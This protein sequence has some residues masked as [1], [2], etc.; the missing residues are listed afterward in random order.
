MKMKL[1]FLFIFVTIEIF[2]MDEYNAYIWNR[3]N[4]LANNGKTDTSP[5]F[6][7]WFY[8]LNIPDSEESFYFVYGI[9]NPWDTLYSMK[10]TRSFVGFGNFRDK[11]SVTNNF[12][13]SDF[14]A[15]YDETNIIISNCTAT[16]KH[17][18][19]Q[20]T[21]KEGSVYTWDLNIQKKWGFNAMG[22]GLNNYR[23]LNIGWFPAQADAVCSGRITSG[24]KTYEISNAPCYQDKNWGTSFPKWWT[25]VV[26]NKFENNENA[27]L[28]VGGGL[29]RILGIQFYSGVSIGLKHNDK[30]YS[31]L[32]NEMSIVNTNVYFG[33]WKVTAKNLLN[34]IIIEA[35]APKEKFMDLQFMTPDGRIFHD[36]ETLN[37]NLSVKLYERESPL[38][39]WKI[40]AD[41][42]SKYAGIEYGSETEYD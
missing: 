4:V 35:S 7:W 8:K 2:S 11:I 24:S 32:P 28:I 21:D 16:E 36:Y 14:F 27:I 18:A 5:W 29:P 39:K 15:S 23:M 26:S 33:T 9:V 19:G 13:V 12:P 34:K 22:W 42:V 1:L 25:W 40:K 41:L 10:G 6:E 37:G 30:I 31:F 20:V 38:S 17:I 3:K